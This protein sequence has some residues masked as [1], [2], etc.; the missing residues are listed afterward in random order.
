M[1]VIY[2]EICVS[3]YATYPTKLHPT[4]DIVE[5]ML[6]FIDPTL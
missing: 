5:I 1:R 6:L 2:W 4:F 3:C